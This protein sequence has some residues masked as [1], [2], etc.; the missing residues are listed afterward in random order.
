MGMVEDPLRLAASIAL[1]QKSNDKPSPPAANALPKADTPDH[2]VLTLRQ[3][4]EVLECLVFLTTYSDKQDVMA[5][6]LEERAEHGG[7]T[8]SIATNSG[9]TDYIRKYVQDIARFLEEQAK[10]PK[11]DQFESLIS[12]IVARTGSRLLRYLGLQESTMKQS[13]AGRLRT[14]LQK[15]SLTHSGSNVP[16]GLLVLS[17]N[18]YDRCKELHPSYRGQDNTDALLGLLGMC[19][20]IW[21]EHQTALREILG[22]IP[23]KAMA[24]TTRE[25][26]CFRLHALGQYQRFTKRLLKYALRNSIFSKIQ[27]RAVHLRPRDLSTHLS[28]W[29]N[30]PRTWLWDMYQSHLA[31]QKAQHLEIIRPIIKKTTLVEMAPNLRQ[32]V[33]D[34]YARNNYKV[35]AEI[36]LLIDYECRPQTQYPPRVLK[37]SKDACFICDLFV[38]THGAFFVPDTHGR[39]YERWALPDLQHLKIPRRRQTELDRLV[40]DFTNAVEMR[41]FIAAATPQRGGK[42]PKEDHVPSVVSTAT[43]ESFQKAKVSMIYSRGPFRNPTQTDQ[44]LADSTLHATLGPELPVN[45]VS[46]VA[47]LQPL[48][49]VTLQESHLTQPKSHLPALVTTSC[50]TDANLSEHCARPC[51]PR[52]LHL[53]PGIPRQHI[54]TPEEPVM[55]F[56][57]PRIHMEVSHEQLLPLLPE[58]T[59][60]SIDAM[61]PGRLKLEAVWLSPEVAQHVEKHASDLIVSLEQEW[62]VLTTRDGALF[63]KQGLLLKNRSDVIQLRL[64]A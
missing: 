12:L 36:Q 8:V 37:A 34:G 21:V 4:Q 44:S 33:Q 9:S 38:R 16:R 32:S 39:V 51:R 29:A 20:D 17:N 28:T 2:R 27:V 62:D 56:H 5:L 30:Q 43:Q 10:S 47:L 13:T 57:T 41:A 42:P 61:S 19:S 55:S 63:T 26:L 35:H 46:S 50:T 64:L 11:E 40:R 3:E 18:L 48:P 6:C 52:I 59:G 14:A 58:N 15:Y 54:F 23:D 7:L 22:Q 1:L 49:Q 60:L 53:A 24:P 45:S 31:R 25:S